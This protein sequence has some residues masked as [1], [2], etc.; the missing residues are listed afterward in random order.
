MQRRLG[1]GLRLQHADRDPAATVGTRL[2]NP[3]TSAAAS[4]GTTK[5]V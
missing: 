1:D 5:S 4:A 3:P 2:W